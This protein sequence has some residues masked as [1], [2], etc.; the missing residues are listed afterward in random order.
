MSDLIDGLT[1]G[2]SVFTWIVSL[3]FMAFW[4][5]AIGSFMRQALGGMNPALARDPPTFKVSILRVFCRHHD[6]SRVQNSWGTKYTACTRCG[7][8][9]NLGKKQEAWR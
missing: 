6:V 8:N 3:C 5:R 4:F 1:L 7:I 9:V 2:F